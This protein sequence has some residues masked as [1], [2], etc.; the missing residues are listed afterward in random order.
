MI[1][2]ISLWDYYIRIVGPTAIP[3]AVLFTI[4]IANGLYGL[5]VILARTPM[6]KLKRAVFTT[7]AVATGAIGVAYGSMG[8]LMPL[9]GILV[10]VERL[11]AGDMS[12]LGLITGGM[13]NAFNS[14]IAGLN[15]LVFA[16]VGLIIWF[17]QAYLEGKRS[18]ENAT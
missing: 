1:E 6:P 4:A 7:V 9:G 14:T 5:Y 10:Q 2:K 18:S 11:G 16:W 17:V 13:R 8:T 3:L 12:S 15:V